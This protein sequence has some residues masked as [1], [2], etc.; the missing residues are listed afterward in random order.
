MDDPRETLARMKAESDQSIEGF[1]EIARNYCAF[2]NACRTNGMKRTEA[3]DLTKTACAE[4]IRAAQSSNSLD[5]IAAL[6]AS[7]MQQADDDD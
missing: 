1:R 2:F 4:Q 7:M 3:L 6:F 5:Q